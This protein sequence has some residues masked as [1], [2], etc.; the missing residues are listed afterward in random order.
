MNFIDDIIQTNKSIVVK[1]SKLAINNWKIFLVGIAYTILS[2]VVWTVASYAWIL[3]GIIAA[4]GQS[5]IISNYLYLIENI[6]NYGKFSI[7]DF[8]SGFQVYLWRIYSIF[9]IFY[10][11]NLG[12]SLFIDPILSSIGVFGVSLRLL[13]N[14]AAFIMLNTIPEVIYQKHYDRLDVITYSFEFTKE[15]WI[16]WFIPNAF[17]A[18]IAYLVHILTSNALFSIGLGYNLV[19]STLV[20]AIIYQLVLAYAM[21]YRGQLFNILSTSTRRKRMFMRNMYK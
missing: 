10:I 9:I 8:K 7:E 2:L 3:G 21:I 16:E 19:V 4:I 6:I 5:A 12:M 14:I 1:S 18:A 20:R 13:I 17:I 15:N 11:V